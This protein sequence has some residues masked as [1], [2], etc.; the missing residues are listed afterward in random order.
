MSLEDI[1]DIATIVGVALALTGA[2]FAY[3]QLKAAT[4]ASESGSI[5]AL[6]EAFARF[7]GVRRKINMNEAF[8]TQDERV[9]LLR[10][11][12]LW[13]RL[14]LLVD[15][16][17]VKLSLVHEIYGSRFE[18]LL[19]RDEPKQIV[20]DTPRGWRNFIALWRRFHSEG[21]CNLP[22]PPPMPPRSR[23]WA[24]ATAILRTRR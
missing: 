20:T 1:A 9:E 11:L 6:D 7:E 3:R 4:A 12:A 19:K 18:E 15:N 16:R 23:R 8:K 14:G 22:D 21:V 10:Y 24:S 17:T 2:L 13:E 5:L